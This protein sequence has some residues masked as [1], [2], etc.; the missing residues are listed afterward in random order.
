[1][2]ALQDVGVTAYIGAAGLISNK[3]YLTSAASAPLTLFVGLLVESLKLLPRTTQS[4][5][6]LVL[7]LESLHIT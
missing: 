5:H 2:N 4:L 1:M 6:R 7:H 3:T